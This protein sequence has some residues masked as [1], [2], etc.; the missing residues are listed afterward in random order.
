MAELTEREINHAHAIAADCEQW[1]FV[2]KPLLVALV[3]AARENL[4]RNDDGE[5]MTALYDAC[6]VER[7]RLRAGI[8]EARAILRRPSGFDYP[9]AVG[10]I[11][12]ALDALARAEGGGG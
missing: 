10:V 8:R 1:A 4:R 12:A 9:G 11:N 5:E 6:V 2:E 3:A 7:D